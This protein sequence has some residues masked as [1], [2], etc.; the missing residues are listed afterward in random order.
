LILSYSL[1]LCD[2]LRFSF[3]LYNLSTARTSAHNTHALQIPL[4]VLDAVHAETQVLYD[5]LMDFWSDES[6]KEI[7]LA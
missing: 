5:Q 4:A 2:T 1:L 3:T 7:D 6:V